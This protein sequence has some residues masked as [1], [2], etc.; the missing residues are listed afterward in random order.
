METDLRDFEDCRPSLLGLAYRM[1]GDMG[2]A[3]D[4]VQDAWLRWQGRAVR[5]E[6]PRAFLL[7]TVT[8]LCLNELSS[9]RARLEDTRSDR[10]P[11]PVSLRDVGLDRV[12]AL[13]RVSMAFLV[14]LQRLTPAERAVLLLHDVFDLGHP[15]IAPL[16]QKSEA[17]CRQ[18]LT[19]ARAAV[20]GARRVLSVAPDTHARLLASFAEAASTGNV[21]AL[22]ALLADDVLLVADAGP[23]GGRFGRVKNLGEPLTGVTKV[24]A[25]LAA[26]GRQGAEGLRWIERELNGFPGLLVVR[27][28]RVEAAIL[29]SVEDACIRGVFIQADPRRLVRLSSALRQ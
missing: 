1:L 22:S 16:L 3:E 19:R 14:L 11:E 21:G 12:E 26:A 9:G 2:R 13:D 29:L 27:G 6:V 10:L 15:D 5:V 18:L 8:R 25:F 24:A 28:D 23:E 20:R 4:I 7:T 17:A